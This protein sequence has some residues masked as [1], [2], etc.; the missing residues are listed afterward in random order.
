[1]WGGSTQLLADD[2]FSGHPGEL[3]AHHTGH[4]GQPEK[5]APSQQCPVSA[6]GGARRRWAEHGQPGDGVWVLGGVTERQH[7]AHR[8]TEQHGRFPH[9]LGEQAVQHSQVGGEPAAAGWE[10]ATAVPEE[11][12]GD[13]PAVIGQQRGEEPPVECRAAEA[14]NGQDD[15]RAGRATEV[16]VVHRSIEVGD[17]RC[18]AGGPVDRADEGRHR[19]PVRWAV[20]ACTVPHT[21]LR[22]TTHPA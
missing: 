21:G 20:P 7:T 3:A 14:M 5:R 15:G 18:G 13:H 22:R 12:D 19:A 9:D 17:V 16:E 11:V 10:A 6:A 4:P 2:L 8:V 1:M